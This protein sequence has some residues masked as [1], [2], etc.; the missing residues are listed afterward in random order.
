MLDYLRQTIIFF[1]VLMFA[2][3][4]ALNATALAPAK[5]VE[6]PEVQGLEIKAT[7]RFGSVMCSARPKEDT[8]VEITMLANTGTYRGGVW[9]L[10]VVDRNQRLSADIKEI[11]AHLSLDGK[12]V[13]TGKGISIGDWIGNK[14]TKSYVR[15][16]FPA[17]DAHIKKLQAARVVKLQA[18]GIYTLK[19]EHLPE[20]ITALEQCQK[21]AKDRQF[22]KGAKNVC[23]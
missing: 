7:Y 22:W 8:A 2:W 14:R 23:K 10:A 9:F 5:E 18:N 16:E 12:R 3:G 19:L 17:I 15:F 1:N 20:I 11:V 13:V 4:F 6:L 21:K